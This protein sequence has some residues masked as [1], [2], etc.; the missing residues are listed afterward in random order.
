MPQFYAQVS[1][2]V[3]SRSSRETYLGAA[4]KL[5][6]LANENFGRVRLGEEE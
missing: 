2:V 5:S 3:T 1:V 6:S 4:T